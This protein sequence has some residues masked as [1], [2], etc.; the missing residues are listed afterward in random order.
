MRTIPPGRGRTAGVAGM[1]RSGAAAAAL[2]S[3]R[4]YRVIGFDSSPQAVP[5][6]HMARLFTGE[7]R[8]EQLRSLDFIAASPGIPLS[9]PIY[10][11]ARALNI[12]VVPEVELGCAAV[13]GEILGVTGSNGKTTTVEWLAH[14]LRGADGYSGSVASGNNGYAMCTAAM[15]NPDS[16]AFALELSSYQ[17]EAIQDLRPVS[18]AVLNLTPD[19]LERHGSMENYAAAKARIFL[20]QLP[21]D[22]GVLNGDDPLLRPMEKQVKGNLLTFSMKRQV[23]RGAWL[24]PQGEIMT[25]ITGKDEHLL[26]AGE[27]GIPGAHNVANALAVACMA[28]SRGITKEETANG[29]RTFR[30]VPHRIEPL[31][32]AAGLNWVNDS[33]STNVDSLKV[34]LESFSSPVILL[35]GGLAKESDYSVLSQLIA[36]RVKF[37]VLFGSA[38]DSLAR[39]WSGAAR[40]IRET[41]LQE[42]VNAVLREASPGDTV[43]LSPG[44]AS[45]DQYSN[46]EER[47]EHF[48]RIVEGLR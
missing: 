47:G 48:R 41:D 40:L 32:T 13:S 10:T 39:Q 5:T 12:Q 18:A 27:L 35:A 8:E 1:G 11:M 25:R 22:T 37:A 24:T 20:N 31:G 17:L 6:E 3:S 15:E 29:L 26:H 7:P 46:F 14:V 42:A 9:A 19:H 2:L 16:P 21:D 4:G 23:E 34:A 28:L 44:C 30:G 43:L 33:K 38:G 36:E 45:F